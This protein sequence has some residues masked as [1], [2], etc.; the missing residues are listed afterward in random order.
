MNIVIS[1]FIIFSVIFLTSCSDNGTQNSESK[2]TVIDSQLRAL[3]KAKGVE[4]DILDSV[5]KQRE[6]IDSY[7]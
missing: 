3:D 4:Q 5:A 1:C 7:Q 2:K 6:Q